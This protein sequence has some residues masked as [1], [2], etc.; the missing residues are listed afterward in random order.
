MEQEKTDVQT[1][2]DTV[3]QSL[4]QA[5]LLLARAAMM[6]VSRLNFV[7]TTMMPK[8]PGRVPF[9][10]SAEVALR[11]YHAASGNRQKPELQ[12]VTWSPLEV[13]EDG[14]HRDY[15][16]R[17]I[18]QGQ[19]L[20]PGC[21]DCLPPQGS[22]LASRT[23]RLLLAPAE[24]LLWRLSGGLEWL[25]PVGTIGWVRFVRPTQSSPKFLRKLESSTKTW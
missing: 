5:N 3:S 2:L 15:R 24:H 20:C 7:R 4:S 16:A 1:R 17:I 25:G 18:P 6:D 22:G 13:V 10:N 11:G 12:E 21:D 9:H 19:Q 14:L 8:Q 23:A